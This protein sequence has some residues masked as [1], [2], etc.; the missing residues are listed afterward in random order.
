M[1]TIENILAFFKI[2]LYVFY[3]A[4]IDI[5]SAKNMALNYAILII[6]NPQRHLI[7]TLMP[8]KFHENGLRKICLCQ[9][10]NN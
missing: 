7:K 10:H 8:S 6:N 4:V 2:C 1:E 9:N 3:K 5:K